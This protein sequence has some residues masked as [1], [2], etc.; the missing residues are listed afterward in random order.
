[1]A[2]PRVFISSTFYDL[3]YIRDDLERLIKEI[4]YEPVRHETGSIPYSKESPLEESAYR[5]VT[6]SDIIVCIIGGR[7]GSDS[8]TRE[9]S[10]TQNELKQALENRIQVY[11]FVEQNVYSEFSTYQINK[12]NKNI[13]YR[14][15]DNVAVFEFLETVLALPQNNPIQSFSTS[16]DIFNFLRSQW[17]GLFQR[18]LQEERR[19]SEIQVLEEMTSVAS[20]L[21][22]LV[23]YLTDERKNKDEA[24]QSILLANHP[25]F[26]AFA[27]ATE[28]KYRVFFTTK[29]ELNT[30]LEARSYKP[31][32][33]EL[34]SDSVAEWMHN[35][36]TKYIKLTHEIFDERGHLLPLKE[37]EW[38]EKWVQVKNINLLPP[39]DDIP[40]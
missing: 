28:T 2:A 9:G 10:I 29:G 30:W 31:G 35:S 7:Y 23:N 21:K 18:F 22:E 11:I 6:L 24:I 13:K 39:E 19:L 15:V 32:S 12:E 16:S 25:A 38:N 4:G 37:G 34:D 3:R 40:F 33:E 1:M 36:N 14:Y 26:R 5:E 27:K 8:T 20:T 17:A